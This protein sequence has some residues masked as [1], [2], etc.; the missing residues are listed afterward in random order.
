[1]GVFLSLVWRT[2]EFRQICLNLIFIFR[3]GCSGKILE[4][5]Q[6]CLVVGVRTKKEEEEEE[7]VRK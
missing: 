1:L 4:F 3:V 6:G 2:I 5:R 7:E